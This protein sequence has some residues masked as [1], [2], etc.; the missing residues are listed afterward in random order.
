MQPTSSP[1]QIY[2]S[3]VLEIPPLYHYTSQAGLLGMIEYKQ[4]WFT[5][6]HYLNDSSEYDYAM[7]FILRVLKDE[8]GI[9]AD[10]DADLSYT[11]Q[12]H[13]FGDVF[14]FSL[15]QRGDQLSQWRGY[16][17][18]GG[19]SVSFDDSQLSEMMKPKKLYIGKCVYD[20]E[21]QKQLIYRHIVGHTPQEYKERF[22]IP[23]IE[24]N[25]NTPRDRV[26]KSSYRR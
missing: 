5:H 19:Y 4:L 24:P 21:S 9:D 6:I 15:S 1:V 17:P 18:N 2:N 23:V 20:E 3:I 25:G 16:C 13:Y 7:E 22:T 10:T 26:P 12:A 8:Y 11:V 14:S